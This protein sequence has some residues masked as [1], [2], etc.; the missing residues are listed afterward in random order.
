MSK[1]KNLTP[2]QEAAWKIKRRDR[3]R[4]YLANVAADPVRAAEK[5]A[6]RAAYDKARNAS[7]APALK[8]KARDARRRQAKKRAADPARQESKKAKRSDWW[9]KKRAADPEWYETQKRLWRE[10][11]ARRKAAK[12]GE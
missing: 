5:K 4:N 6:K 1:P 3:H 11:Y 8:R 7:L 9:H 12:A 2:E 10:A